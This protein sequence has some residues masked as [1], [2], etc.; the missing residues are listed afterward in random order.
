MIFIS[1]FISVFFWQSEGNLTP[2][3]YKF[4]AGIMFETATLA[5]LD[6]VVLAGCLDKRLH[7]HNFRHYMP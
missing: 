5:Y 4:V 1:K 2:H 7:L 6:I 3:I